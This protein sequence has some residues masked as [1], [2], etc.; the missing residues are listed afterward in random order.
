MRV[1]K[2]LATCGI[3]SRRAVEQYIQDGRVKIN[4]AIVTDLA[5]QILQTDIV[6]FDGAV[7]APSDEKVYIALN[8]PRGC[9]TTCKDDKGRRTVLDVINNS[10]FRKGGD[11]QRPE[12][13]TK[14]GFFRVF[15]VGRLDYDTEGLLLLTND[16]DFANYVMHPSSNIQ[17]TYVATVD[18]EVTLDNIRKLQLQA[19]KVVLRSGMVLEITIHEGKNRQVRKMCEGVGL[20]VVHLRRVS[21]GHL[22]LDKLKLQK[23]EWKH[24]RKPF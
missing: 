7:V 15:P 1:N 13:E 9:L 18:S 23:G 8:K 4:G 5:R 19:D 3:G 22:S 20:D 11:T 10:P 16:G 24:I 6:E 12:R 21:I 14:M 17:K 2:F